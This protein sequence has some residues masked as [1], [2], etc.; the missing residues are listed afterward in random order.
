MDILEQI[1]DFNL[2]GYFI[3]LRLNYLIRGSFSVY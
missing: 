2:L 3:Q 1:W